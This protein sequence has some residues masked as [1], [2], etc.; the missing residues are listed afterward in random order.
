[1]YDDSGRRL[2]PEQAEYF[3]DSL[4]KDES[5]RLKVMYHGTPHGGFREFN[6]RINQ[7]GYYG[8]GSYFTDRRDRAEMYARKISNATPQIYKVYLNI[9]W[10]MD[11]DSVAKQGEWWGVMPE[12]DF[13]E[14]GFNEDFYFAAER[15]YERHGKLHSEAADILRGAIEDMGYDGITYIHY[16]RN[17]KNNEERVYIA[18]EPQQIKRVTNLIPTDSID[19]DS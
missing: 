1:M 6:T 5:G 18:F 12:V 13:P 3:K 19:I 2:T 10:P 14:E 8:A 16:P 15:Y 9:T 17:A 4:V 11:M 7:Y